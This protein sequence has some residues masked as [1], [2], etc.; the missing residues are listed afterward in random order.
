MK[1]VKSSSRTVAIA[2]L[3]IAA[4]GLFACGKKADNSSPPT[5]PN[6]ISG[7]AGPTTK[8]AAAKPPVA[9]PARGPEHAD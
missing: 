3:A 4:G 2:G 8:T 5:K 9:A 6:G 7:S 1:S